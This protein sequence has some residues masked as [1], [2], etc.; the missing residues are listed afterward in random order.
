MF[1]SLLLS[2][3]L[4]SVP[5]LFS[6]HKLDKSEGSLT[7]PLEWHVLFVGFRAS[8]SSLVQELLSKELPSVSKMFLSVQLEK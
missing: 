8:E 4:I 7:T 3:G 5:G 2:E 6:S 1:M